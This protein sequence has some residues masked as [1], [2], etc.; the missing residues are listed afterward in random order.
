LAVGTAI[1]QISGVSVGGVARFSIGND[2]VG[3]IDAKPTTLAY[4]PL[5]TKDG[6]GNG[7]AIQNPGTGSV[8]VRLRLIKPDGSIDQTSSPAGLNPL[9]AFGQFSRFVGSEMGFVNPVQANST[10]EIAVQGTGSIAILPL[11][12]G[13][14]FT[15]SGSLITSDLESP[16]F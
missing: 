14:G 7:V 2:S 12:L 10:L 16:Q 1:F 13:N 5:T 9:P 11:L 6:F 15:S 3:V 4:I 8:N